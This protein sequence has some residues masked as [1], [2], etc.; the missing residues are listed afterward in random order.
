MAGFDVGVD[1]KL[2]QDVNIATRINE[3]IVL[4]RDFIFR[5]SFCIELNRSTVA[6]SVALSGV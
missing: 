3:I 4:L 2:L 5:L 6:L 1:A